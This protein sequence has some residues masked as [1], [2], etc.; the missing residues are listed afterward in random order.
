MILLTRLW[1]KCK[2]NILCLIPD[3][4][5]KW[6]KYHSK[7]QHYFQQIWRILAV[8]LIAPW[9]TYIKSYENVYKIHIRI[10]ITI[11]IDYVVLSLFMESTACYIWMKVQ[12]ILDPMDPSGRTTNYSCRPRMAAGV[13]KWGRDCKQGHRCESQ[14]YRSTNVNK[15]TAI[16]IIKI[17]IDDLRQN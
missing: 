4:N 6:H 3:P 10:L 12:T 15:S 5:P 13:P 17:F 16:S 7:V 2:S 14:K 8:M 1:C 9:N 11:V